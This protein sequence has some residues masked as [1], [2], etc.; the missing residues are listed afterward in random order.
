MAPSNSTPNL[1]TMPPE[2]LLDIMSFA[3]TFKS[4]ALLARTCSRLYKTLIDEVYKQ[5]STSKVLVGDVIYEACRDGNVLTLERFFINDSMICRYDRS[6]Y[7]A[8]YYYQ[9]DVV[10]WLLEHGTDPNFAVNQE[11]LTLSDLPLHLAVISVLE[12]G[13]PQWR[14]P[15]KWRKQGFVMPPK[16]YWRDAGRAIIKL[17]RDAG[18]DESDVLTQIDRDHLDS[19]QANRNTSINRTLSPI[20]TST[21]KDKMST[22]TPTTFP[23]AKLPLE[24]VVKILHTMPFRSAGRLVR[25]NKTMYALLIKELYKSTKIRGWFP[26]G[27]ACATNNVRTLSLCL[28]AGAPP[29]F[30]IP[31]DLGYHRWSDASYYAVGGCRAL[32]ET[33]FRMRSETAVFLLEHG[34]N[35]DTTPDE[36]RYSDRSPLE[37]AYQR[38]SHNNTDVVHARDICLALVDAGCD[39][40]TLSVKKRVEIFKMRL[41]KTYFPAAWS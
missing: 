5:A 22:T 19:I 18:A 17:L 33:L 6:L 35:P 8:I 39:F 40:S 41:D 31:K 2:I 34:A 23:L 12:P 20:R 32:R 29:D 37:Y 3:D 27:F 28:D 7:T 16:D 10:R 1:H 15:M 36:A 11:V 13:I 9:V 14:I 4:K 21:T 26:L 25:S 24:L 38:G 30:H